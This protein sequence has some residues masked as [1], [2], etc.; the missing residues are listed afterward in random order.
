MSLL[1]EMEKKADPHRLRDPNQLLVTIENISHIKDLDALMETVLLEA[2]RFVNAD[3]GTIYLVSQNHLFFSYV[4]NDTL[5]A[6]EQPKEKYIYAREKMELNKKSLAG[7]VAST[8][9]SLLIDDVYDIKSDVSYS[10][11]VSFDTK[12]NYR[13]KSILVV[14]LTT[15]DD[16]IVGVLQ[17][18]NAKDRKG[19]II[20]FSMQDRLYIT[21]FAHNAA[22][23]IEKAQLSQELVLRMVHMAELRD[24]FETAQHA[25]RVGAYSIEIYK[26]WAQ[27]HGT[28]DREITKTIDIL[29]A[30]AIL[31]DVGKVAVSDTILKKES[32]LSYEERMQSRFHVIYGARLFRRT[33]SPWDAMAA[34]VALNHHEWFDGSGYPGKIDDIYASRIYFGPGKKTSEIPISARIVSAADVYDALVSKRAYKP[35]WKDEHALKHIRLQSGKHFD[36][37]IVDLLIGLEE[38]FAEIRRRFPELSEQP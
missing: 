28:P 26:Q 19:E 15:R 36:P 38:T 10:F 16:N 2:R 18:I 21:Q 37:E 24:P 5:F 20:P 30:A 17:L 8:G 25:R 12:A 14:P 7:Y 27:R 22:H 3:A 35:A 23:A 6:G 4:Q 34:E 11:N 33:N 1:K 31:H 9:Q 29:R 13:T 32:S